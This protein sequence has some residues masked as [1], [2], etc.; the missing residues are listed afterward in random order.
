MRTLVTLVILGA[1]YLAGQRPSPELLVYKTVGGHSIHA[2]FYRP[3]GHEVRPLIFW[4]HGGALIGGHRG[5]LR[6]D[7]LVRYLGAGYAVLSI[8]YRLAPETKLP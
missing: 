5:N 6:T 2:D 7:Q 4:I 1:A 3:P 8:D